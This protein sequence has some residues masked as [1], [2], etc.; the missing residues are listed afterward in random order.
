MLSFFHRQLKET[1]KELYL[2]GDAEKAVHS[3]LAGYFGAQPHS[4]GGKAFNVRKLSELP[5]QL[6]K[7]GMWE[8]LSET[9]CDLTFIEAKCAA[10]LIYE[11]LADYDSALQPGELPINLRP[12]FT[13][14]ARFVR[15]QS[16]V[17]RD[18]PDLLFQQ[19]LNEPDTSVVSQAAR[20][21]ESRELR[22][23]F[24]WI[25]KP[26]TPSPC[27]MTLSGHTDFVNSCDV[28]PDGSKILSASADKD[29]KI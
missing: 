22:P 28:S 23:Y 14:F 18:H 21:L 2:E 11:L 3:R 24:Q 19:A 10:G 17:L 1:A 27:V 8:Q 6:R 15:A 29:L 20:F 13:E 5:Y 7:A 9:L 4:Y 26:Q 16:H 12:R 25:N